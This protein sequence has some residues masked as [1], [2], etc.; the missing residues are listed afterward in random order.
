[1]NRSTG[2]FEGQDWLEAELA[3]T[4]DE[5]Y[6]LELSEP[7]LSEEIRKIYRK[8]HPP[9]LPRIDYFRALIALQSE[10]IKL[11]DWSCT[12]RKRSW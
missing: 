6:E 10:L 1:M 12:T 7:A 5:D 4:L 3:D 8:S 9:S 2:D 11:Q